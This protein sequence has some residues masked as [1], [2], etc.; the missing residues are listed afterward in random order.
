MRMLKKYTSPYIIVLYSAFVVCG[1]AHQSYS[2]DSRAEGEIAVVHGSYWRSIR[3]DKAMI[4]G[5]DHDDFGTFGHESVELLPGKHKVYISC[6]HGWNIATAS[7]Y[8]YDEA[9]EF[10]AEPGHHYKARCKFINDKQ[11]SW[12]EDSET[13]E[14]VGGYDP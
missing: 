9:I 5:I 13:G 10:E 11:W 6:Y 14:I 4:I 7:L 3:Y 1:C 2:G 12:V 8:G